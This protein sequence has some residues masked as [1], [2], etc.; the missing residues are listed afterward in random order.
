V[1]IQKSENK[2]IALIT[3]VM[4]ATVAWAMPWCKPLRQRPIMWS[5]ETKLN[6]QHRLSVVR[7]IG[8]SFPQSYQR[9]GLVN[10]INL[11]RTYLQL[12]ASCAG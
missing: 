3:T 1:I 4:Q 11:G 5:A 12:R 6:A 7:S 2:R 10:L 8:L 9:L